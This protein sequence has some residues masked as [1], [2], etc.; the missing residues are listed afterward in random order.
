[1][2]ASSQDYLSEQIP[3][4]HCVSAEFPQLPFVVFWIFTG[5]IVVLNHCFTPLADTLLLW[6]KDTCAKEG[7]LPPAAV[8][9]DG[10]VMKLSIF[11]K[12]NENS[13]Q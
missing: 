8:L 12:K 1:M 11:L 6:V 5:L 7:L 3:V 9:K 10:R 4:I 13:S 2:S